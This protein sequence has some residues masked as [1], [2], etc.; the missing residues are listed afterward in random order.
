M[1][2]RFFLCSGMTRG[3]LTDTVG[4]RIATMY[5][6]HDGLHNNV[7][8]AGTNA[9]QTDMLAFR[10]HLAWAPS[11]RTDLLLTIENGTND[12]SFSRIE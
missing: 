1:T 10:G 6:K 3:A 5:H 2:L 7:N 4:A 11:D 12:I 8:S 9:N